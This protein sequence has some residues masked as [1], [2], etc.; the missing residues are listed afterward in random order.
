MRV[1]IGVIVAALLT[2]GAWWGYG[3]LQRD[4]THDVSVADVQAKVS[5]VF[6]LKKCAVVCIEFADP[7]VTLPA[8]AD[9][10]ELTASLRASLGP[11]SFPGH[12]RLAARPRY[13]PA[14]ASVYLSDIKIPDVTLAGVPDNVIELVK[15]HGPLLANVALAEQPIYR[16]SDAG[17]LGEIA[18]RGLTDIRVADG[19]L[20]LTFRVLNAK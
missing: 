4:I 13:D 17:T 14:T 12:A 16:I 15:Q 20:R 2:A 8:S 9:K 10:V 3:R 18:K 19:K 7:R 6:P 1:V 11:L 5:T